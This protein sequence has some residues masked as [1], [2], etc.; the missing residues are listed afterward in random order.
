MAG[1]NYSD[2]LEENRTQLWI[3]YRDLDLQ[4]TEEFDQYC[5]RIYE[6]SN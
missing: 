6:Q 1:V 2:W 4:D 3:Q 5:Q